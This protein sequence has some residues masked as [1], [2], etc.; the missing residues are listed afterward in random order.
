MS[1][2][3]V[4]DWFVCAMC[5]IETSEGFLHLGKRYCTAC[6]KKVKEQLN[7]TKEGE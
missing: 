1:Q 7:S 2:E 3:I 6:F 5:G 4:D